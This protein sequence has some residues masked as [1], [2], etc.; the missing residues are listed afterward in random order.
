MCTIGKVHKPLTDPFLLSANKEAIPFI[1]SQ[2]LS[3]QRKLCHNG[4][5]FRCLFVFFYGTRRIL[6]QPV[7][8][9]KRGLQTIHLP[10]SGV[11][12]ALLLP[13]ERRKRRRRPCCG[14]SIRMTCSSSIAVRDLTSIPLSCCFCYYSVIFRTVIVM[15]GP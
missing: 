2:N 13:F 1:L 3:E 12:C 7:R 4:N 10:S 5:E 9:T 8:D 14:A 11:G 6:L 15:E